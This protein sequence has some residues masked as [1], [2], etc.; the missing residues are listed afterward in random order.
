MFTIKV[1]QPGSQDYTAY[2][3]TSFMRKFV[4]DDKSP[5]KRSYELA[6]QMTGEVP[7]AIHLVSDGG[8]AYI[9]NAAG[10]TID[11]LESTAS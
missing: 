4:G 8:V 5:D 2:T 10:K 7:N 9:E 3:C 11:K 1:F 6:M